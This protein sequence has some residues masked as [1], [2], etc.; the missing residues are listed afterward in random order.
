MATIFIITFE[1]F[2]KMESVTHYIDNA[3]YNESDAKAHL[4]WIAS[5]F[6]MTQDT[7][8]ELNENGNVLYLHTAIYGNFS[9]YRI[10]KQPIY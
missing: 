10:E 9:C 8:P 7:E 2:E 1:K 6:T 3:F 4:K 5:D